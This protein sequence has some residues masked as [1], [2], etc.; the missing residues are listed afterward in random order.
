MRNT[1]RYGGYVVHFGIVLIF[2]GFSGSAFNQDKQMDMP[3]GAQMEIGPYKLVHQTFDTTPTTNY[4]SERATIAVDHDGQQTIML[5]PERRFYP[6]N[7]ESGTMVAVYSTLKEDLY[8]VY[9]GRSPE[10]QRAGDPRL[11]ESAGEMGLAG[12]NWSSSWARSWRWCRTASRC[13][14]WHAPRKPVPAGP[15]PSPAHLPI[16]RRES[17]D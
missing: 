8:V 2:I 14:R 13:W 1:R 5:Y 7:E 12:R 11:S 6:S 15:S 10:T 17:H 9:A 4:S 3:V 16:E